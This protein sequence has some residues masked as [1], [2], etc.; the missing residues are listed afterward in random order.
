[1]RRPV[2][3]NADEFTICPLSDWAACQERERARARAVEEQAAR[4]AVRAAGVNAVAVMAPAAQEEP[5]PVA[6]GPGR[7]R[8]SRAGKT[9]LGDK[10]EPGAP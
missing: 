2:D 7:V 5:A 9:L 1:M 6:A 8:A 4:E 10:P 3:W